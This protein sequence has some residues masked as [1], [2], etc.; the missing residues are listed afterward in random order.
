M[1][2]QIRKYRI[3]IWILGSW[4][5]LALMA[6]FLASSN[7]LFLKDESGWEFIGPYGN[8]EDSEINSAEKV[9]WSPVPFSANELDL[10]NPRFSYP[11]TNNSKYEFPRNHL[12]GTDRVGRDIMAGLIHGARFSLLVVLAS[13]IS[14]ALIGLLIGILMGFF[15][16]QKLRVKIS[17]FI[18]VILGITLP[19]FW[20]NN[21]GLKESFIPIL[22][23]LGFF[24]GIFL[25]LDKKIYSKANRE[26]K[27][28]V[29]FLLSRILEIF[30]TIP[31]LFLLLVIISLYDPSFDRLIM[32]L[33]LTGWLTLAKM[34]RGKTLKLVNSPL[35]ENLKSLGASNS[36]IIWLHLIPFLLPDF[37]AYLAYLSGNIILLES[38]LTFLG[39]GTSPDVVSWGSLLSLSL[40]NPE[41]W[42]LAV[43]PGLLIFAV[44]YSLV[45]VGDLLY[46]KLNP[47]QTNWRYYDLV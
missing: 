46:S 34:M 20:I 3:P 15:G 12:L 22:I 37:L 21:M 19:L 33:V 6:D 10:S 29:D 13:S 5:L 44:V 23:L 30:E 41:F 35:F 4:I 47:E 18:L 2:I 16:D 31:K 11:G 42:W 36:R 26:I 39:L 32:A 1:I 9:F 38:A 7:P 8:V 40:Y 24:I 43:L 25:L 45:R 28:P 17:G 27:L 14:I